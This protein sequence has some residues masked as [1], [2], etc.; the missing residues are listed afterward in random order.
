M[1]ADPTEPC[2]RHGCGFLPMLVPVRD[3]ILPANHCSDACADYTWL[4]RTLSTAPVTDAT[5][6]ALVAM[7]ELR[8]LLDARQE[9]NDMGPLVNW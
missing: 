7:E 1:P 2:A 6:D 5:P 8:Q 3:W 4:E 9:P